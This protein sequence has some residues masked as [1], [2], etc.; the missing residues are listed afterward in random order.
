MPTLLV[1]GDSSSRL[2]AEAL[3][4]AGEI[5]CRGHSDARICSTCRRIGEGSHPDFLRLG[6]DGTQIRVESV[7]EAIR[8]AAGRPYE[9]PGRVVWIESAEALREGGAANA[10]LKS[11]EEPGTFLTWILTTT[12]PDAILGTI[13]SRCEQRRLARRSTADRRA[14]LVRRGLS[15]A[16]VDDAVAFELDES[17]EIDLAPARELRREALAAL[18]TGATSPLLTIAASA[19]EEDRAPRIVA[20][21]LRDAAVLASGGGADRLRHRAVAADIA[22]IAR[23]HSADALRRAAVEV[24]ALPERFQRFLQ[25]KLAWE[26]ALLELVSDR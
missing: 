16:D 9:A 11:L 17:D 12:V 20:G 6:P 25:K 7:R 13:R 15:P 21:L 10:L 3:R 5:L 2:R 26:R 24:D 8:F 4:L 22:A 1:S 19:A 14:D 18:A 23:V